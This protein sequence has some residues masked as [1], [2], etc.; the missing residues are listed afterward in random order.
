MGFNPKGKRR[1]IVDVPEIAERGG[2]P[3]IVLTQGQ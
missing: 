2:K 3:C 1:D